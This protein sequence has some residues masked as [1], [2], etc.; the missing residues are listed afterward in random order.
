VT[1]DAASSAA[2]AAA[3][4]AESSAAPTSKGSAPLEPADE[5]F[6]QPFL[7]LSVFTK[8]V[9]SSP[10]LSHFFEQDLSSSFQLRAPAPQQES[11]REALA[12]LA[13]V[14]VTGGGGGQSTARRV[15]GL[16]GGLLGEVGDRVG[17][18]TGRE[19]RTGPLPS[20]GQQTPASLAESS[21]SQAALGAKTAA[22]A[23]SS[24]GRSVQDAEEDVRAATARLVEQ[25][26]SSEGAFVID[27][28]VGE[29]EEDEGDDDD[30]EAGELSLAAL[31]G[32]E[33]E[34][35]GGR[36]QRIAKGASPHSS[37][38]PVC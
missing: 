30:E 18:V 34:Q 25:A 12:T 21:T 33:E 9:Q 13:A 5:A 14:A 15:R 17:K 7:A 22:A 24:L 37:S 35:A 3:P 32:G 2:P 19:T 6:D 16:L 20:F 8:L 23:S 29:D 4:Q 11:A 38:T 27:E 28:A 1:A 31:G 36:E 26:A 10:V